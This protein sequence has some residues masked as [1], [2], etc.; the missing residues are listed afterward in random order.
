MS[1][2]RQILTIPSTTSK[3]IYIYIGGA[4]QSKTAITKGLP[5]VNSQEKVASIKRKCTDGLPDVKLKHLRQVWIVKK[6]MPPSRRLRGSYAASDDAA[7]QLSLASECVE[8]LSNGRQRLTT[9]HEYISGKSH[10]GHEILEPK[11]P[12]VH[13]TPSESLG[14]GAPSPLSTLEHHSGAVLDWRSDGSAPYKMFSLGVFVLISF[15][16]ANMGRK[17]ICRRLKKPRKRI[18][19]SSASKPSVTSPTFISKLKKV[20]KGGTPNENLSN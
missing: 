16:L 8:E 14:L 15:L 19:R 1:D 11:L 20:Y 18:G 4:L 12:D 9:L 13:T 7:F 5:N 6:N 3:E 10:D 2:N 17:F